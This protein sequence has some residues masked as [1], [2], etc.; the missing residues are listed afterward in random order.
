MTTC[1]LVL[2]SL[3]TGDGNRLLLNRDNFNAGIPNSSQTTVEVIR[4][5]WQCERN[6]NT[7]ATCQLNTEVSPQ[8]E[9]EQ[10]MSNS[11]DFGEM[12]NRALMLYRVRMI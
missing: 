1:R 7:K 12:K 8:E 11:K 10:E 4:Q 9:E 3:L 5:R 6:G 2:Q